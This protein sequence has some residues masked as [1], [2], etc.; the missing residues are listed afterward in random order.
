[1]LDDL[2]LGALGLQSGFVIAVIIAAVLVA[3]RLGGDGQLALRATQVAIGVAILLLATSATTAILDTPS[4]PGQNFY[5]GGFDSSSEDELSEFVEESAE[6]SSETGTVHLGVGFVLMATGVAL[7]RILRAIPPGLILGGL[8]LLLLGSSA[9]GISS[10]NILTLAYGDVG[11]DAGT[12]REV[13]RVLVLL[14]G[15][16]LLLWC[17]YLRWERPVTSDEPG[18]IFPTAPQTE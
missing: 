16:L 7:H 6:R 4:S 2:G 13:L 14:A 17:V 1:M 8:L 9:G 10:L 18:P 15:T 12:A 11:S 3:N 5:D